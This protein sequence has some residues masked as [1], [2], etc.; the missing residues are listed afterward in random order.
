MANFRGIEFNG[1]HSYVDFGL[2][3]ASRNIGNPSKIKRSERIPYSNVEYDFSDIYGDQEYE[4]RTLTYSFNV[5]DHRG[6]KERLVVLE[7]EVM[8]WILSTKSKTVLKDDVVLGYYFLAEAIGHD[9]TE[10]EGDALLTVTFNAYP[11][12]IANNDE[13]T[14]IWDTFNFLTDYAQTTE[15]NVSGKLNVTLYNPSIKR[16][17]PKIKSTAQMQIVN[18]GI[19][20]NIPT[21]ESQSYDFLLDVGENN[22]SIIGNGTISFHYRKERI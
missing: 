10:N 15:F 21:G 11:F 19:T 3:I 16:L 17:S 5:I 8:N 1:K 13:G 20:Y 12:K 6:K 9:I 4:E 7:D 22:I 2:T 14:D 18:D